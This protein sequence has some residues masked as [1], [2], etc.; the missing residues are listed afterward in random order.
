M[1]GWNKRMKWEGECLEMWRGLRRQKRD[2]TGTDEGDKRRGDRE[3]SGEVQALP[4][5]AKENGCR[6]GRY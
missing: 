1:M 6:V 5:I 3:A 4:E 2:G